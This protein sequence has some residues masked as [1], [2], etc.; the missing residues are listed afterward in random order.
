[1]KKLSIL[2]FIAYMGAQ[3]YG[4]GVWTGTTVPTTTTAKTGIGTTTPEAKLSIRETQ[5]YLSGGGYTGK[6]FIIENTDGIGSEFNIMEVYNRPATF[7]ASNYSLIYWLSNN[8]NF[9]LKSLATGGAN[10]MVI[11][12]STGVLSNMPMPTLS[13]S[14]NTLSI[15]GGNSVTLPT[16]SSGDNLGNHTATTDLYMNSKSINAVNHITGMA[17]SSIDLSGMFIK[18][19]NQL[20]IGSVGSGTYELYVDGEAF[21]TTSWQVSDEKFKKNIKSFTGI[22]EKLF[23]LNPYIYNFRSEEFKGIRNFDN[24]IHYGFMAQEIEP[25]FPNLVHKDE[26]G[27]YSVNYIEF[28]PLLLESIKEQSKE[29]DD[30]KSRL[31]KLENK[32]NNIS[33]ENAISKTVRTPNVSVLDQNIPN[34]FDKETKIRFH[35][36]QDYS[37]AFIGIYDLSGKQIKRI[38]INKSQSEIVVPANILPAGTYIYSLVV[39]GQLIDSKRMIVI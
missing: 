5:S 10:K 27:E 2:C 22:K 35:V 19:N 3:M 28:I 9:G 15:S 16:G 20:H 39:E 12:N 23:Q 24:R 38:P 13:L 32:I 30:L 34:P 29:I 4:Q 33:S 25:I 26:H 6:S 7:P 11:S 31:E 14:G 21:C 18:F 36:N 17:G 8:G 37:S 1:M